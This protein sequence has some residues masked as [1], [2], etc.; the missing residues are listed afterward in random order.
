MAW[1][2][3][4]WLTEGLC[5]AAAYVLARWIWAEDGRVFRNLPIELLTFAVLYGLFLLLIR[6]RKYVRRGKQAK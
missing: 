1:R 3:T 6:G 5:G 4:G 2:I